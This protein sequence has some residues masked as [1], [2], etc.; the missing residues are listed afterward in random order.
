ML[1][2]TRTVHTVAGTWRSP[3]LLC[4]TANLLSLIGLPAIGA[5]LTLDATASDREDILPP[6]R[7]V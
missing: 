4:I 6:G 7:H 1:A 5:S 2:V 3:R